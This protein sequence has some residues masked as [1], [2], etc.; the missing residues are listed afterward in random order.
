MRRRSPPS[1]PPLRVRESVAAVVAQVMDVRS[2]AWFGPLGEFRG[3]L[4]GEPESLGQELTRRLA[5]LGYAG[6]IGRGAG[7]AIVRCIPYR[8][9][10]GGR[11]T[12][13]WLSLLLLVGTLATTMALG[14]VMSG[15][16]WP[17]AGWS[18]AVAVM[19]VLGSHEL[20][21]YLAARAHNL[22]VTLPLFI[23]D[24]T[25]L[26]SGTG[27]GWSPFGTFGALIK[28][29]SLIPT[30]RALV[31]VGALGPL[32]GIVVSAVVAAVGLRLP[33]PAP[34]GPET[35]Y[36]L[37]GDP[38]LFKGMALL[39]GATGEEQVLHPVAFAGWVGM[40]V[41]ALNLLP[42]AQLDG[43]HIA[44]ALFGHRQRYV[45]AAALLTLAGLG[46]VWPGWFLFGLVGLA[47]NRGRLAHPPLVV[48][49]GRLSAERVLMGAAALV[50]LVVCFTPRPVWIPGMEEPW[51]A[52]LGWLRGLL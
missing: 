38:L 40:F 12:P 52:L 11:R 32:A 23:P 30:R 50:G 44:Y 3:I 1:P 6:L 37:L 21:H 31:D 10:T 8:A 7:E 49:G 9:R 47:L 46:L 24:F 51:R 25:I 22:D 20:G 39:V 15:S 29:R 26:L 27:V 41:T 43:G 18:Y 36:L 33:A 42:I 48:E 34:A 16:D 35:S 19:L 45:S 2:A 5:S 14:A 17:F 13:A 28:M 4:L